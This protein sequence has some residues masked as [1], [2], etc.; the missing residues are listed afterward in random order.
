MWRRWRQLRPGIADGGRVISIQLGAGC[1]ITATRC[2]DAVDTSM[3]FTPLEGLV[4]ATRSGD[5]DP[6]LLTFLQ[7]AEGLKPE[8]L[9]RLLND[10]SGLLGLSGESADMKCLLD[11][12]QPDASLAVDV[13][14]YRVR[15]YIGAYVA[16][17][18]GA[19]AILFGGGVGE[20]APAPRSKILSGLEVLG[21]S[22][23]A[24]ANRAA[25]GTEARISGDGSKVEVWVVPVE[26]AKILACAAAAVVDDRVSASAKE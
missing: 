3:G 19:D 25:I 4:M 10:E 17:L 21:I 5:V 22:L 26:E 7:R 12:R 1:S 18:G 11:S 6:G 13:Y 8:Q 15:K 24:S 2:G 23:D 16:V 9:E 14:C 20:H